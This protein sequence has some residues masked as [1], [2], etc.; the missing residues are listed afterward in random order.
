MRGGG[1]S[2][3]TPDAGEVVVVDDMAMWSGASNSSVAWAW[4]AFGVQH[5]CYE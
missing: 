5:I 1:A 4:L 2:P 3:E